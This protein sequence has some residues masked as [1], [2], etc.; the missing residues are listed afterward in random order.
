MAF[1]GAT[2]PGQCEPGSDG[3]KGVL[4]IRQSFSITGTSPSDCLMSYQ[5]HSLVGLTPL[6]RCSRCILQPQ[7]T[8][9]I[10]ICYS[11]D[12]NEL[13]TKNPGRVIPMI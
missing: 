12:I 6:Q 11:N 4:R 2:T 7:P 10:T 3:N 9:Q 1:S 5:G 13:Y 8:G